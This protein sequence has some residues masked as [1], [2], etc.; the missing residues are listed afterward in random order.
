MIQTA[1]SVCFNDNGG[2]FVKRISDIV[3]GSSYNMGQLEG[4]ETEGSLRRVCTCF[5]KIA[6]KLSS[7]A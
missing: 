6:T 4:Q 3:T 7:R 5:A 1:F 2:Y